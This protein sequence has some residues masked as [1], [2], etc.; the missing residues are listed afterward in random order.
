MIKEIENRVK[1]K[2]VELNKKAFA[3]GFEIG[4]NYE[5]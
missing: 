1:A 5:A 3:L 4:H 2:F